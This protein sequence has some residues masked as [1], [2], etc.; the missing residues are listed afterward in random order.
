ML[1]IRFLR[2][3]RKN[4]PSYKIVVTDKRKP[5]RGGRFVEILGFYNPITKKKDIK[6]ERVQYWLGKGAKPSDSVHNL[7]VEGKVVEGKKINVSKNKKSKEEDKTTQI[8]QAAPEPPKE[9]VKPEPPKEAVK[10]AIS[11]EEP[12]PETKTTLETQK[13]ASQEPQK[14]PEPIKPPT[15]P[16]NPTPPSNP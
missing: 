4:Q 12:K 7:L 5:P 15:P 11:K 14:D 13:P 1:V 3:G 9:A 2:I 16:T 8:P 10:E 6:K